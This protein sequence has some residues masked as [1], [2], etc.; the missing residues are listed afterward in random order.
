MLCVFY[1]LYFHP[2]SRYPGP[3]LWAVSRLPF[4]LAMRSGHLA[5]RI[6][7]FHEKYGSVVR[8][9][10]GEL[11]FIDPAASRDIY[12]HRPG[13]LPFPKSIVWVP[14]PPKNSGRTPSI[15]NANDEDHA[16]IRKAWSY[17][18]SD[19]SLKDQEPL[20]IGHVDTLI[21]KLGKA[22]SDSSGEINLVKWFDYCTFDIIGDLAFG[23][24]FNCMH[25]DRYHDWVYGLVHHFKAAVITSSIRHFPL[26]Y[27]F[28]MWTIPKDSLLKQQQHL[29]MAREKV[30]R[31]LS[32]EKD[33]PDL[34]S[35]LARSREGLSAA[36]IEGTAATI[37]VAGSN[38]MANTL[39]G[40]M[41][42][43]IRSPQALMKLT[44]EIRGTY[45]NKADMNI[46]NLIQLP[47]LSA[48]VE[49]GL[50]IVSPV[51]LGMAR[52]VPKGGDIV[53]N[54]WLPENVGDSS[55]LF[56]L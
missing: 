12:T 54:Q 31:R 36:E 41:N 23:E 27:C 1:R 52:M 4:V 49:E 43:L 33:R 10:P 22:A 55:F 5:H 51:P 16:R 28:L 44:K 8:I 2:L 21:E 9:A 15:L 19:K 14:P 56:I 45:N 6:Q 40:T 17:G 48:V 39:S 50:R 46:G 38:S 3:S 24:S 35:H 11:S 25:E 29:L 37:I 20:I 32:M 26:L 13:H 47:Y 34:L 30:Q 7:S 53:C 18:F 42:Y